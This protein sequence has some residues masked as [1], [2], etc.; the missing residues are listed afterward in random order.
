[1]GEGRI[2]CRRQVDGARMIRRSRC[3]RK[4]FAARLVLFVGV[5]LAAAGLVVLFS[6]NIGGLEAGPMSAI[7]R[8]HFIFLGGGCVLALGVALLLI[9]CRRLG[10]REGIPRSQE[11]D[12]PPRS[13]R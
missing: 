7:E 6:C 8:E 5:I 10:A 2:P 3:A 9:G 13:D 11:H 12:D 1:M 4:Q